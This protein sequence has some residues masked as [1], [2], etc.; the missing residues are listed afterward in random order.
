MKPTTVV[1]ITKGMEY[2]VFIGRPSKWGNPFKIGGDGTR[3][4]VIEKYRKRIMARPALLKDLHELR[5]R[6]LGC[7]CFPKP[8]HG[9]ILAKLA[10]TLLD[11]SS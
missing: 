2:D 8:C 3:E 9:D 7:F 6:R 10:N 4:Q 11:E 5:G 1:N